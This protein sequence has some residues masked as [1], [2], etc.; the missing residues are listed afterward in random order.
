[1]FG[2]VSVW[3]WVRRAARQLQSEFLPHLGRVVPL[4]KMDVDAA[5]KLHVLPP[6]ALEVSAVTLVWQDPWL[7]ELR[8]LYRAGLGRSAEELAF[9]ANALQDLPFDAYTV[10]VL[11]ADRSFVTVARVPVAATADGRHEC[12]IDRLPA[13][14]QFA[15]RIS[16]ESTTSDAGRALGSLPRLE[17][18]L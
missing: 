4:V 13:G 10:Q 17:R 16:R 2:S 6:D 5:C 9:A 8:R 11:T 18:A 15:F 7:A 14:R 12:R 3:E 1:M